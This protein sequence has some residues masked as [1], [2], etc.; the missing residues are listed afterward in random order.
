[1]E[2]TDLGLPEVGVQEPGSVVPM[3]FKASARRFSMVPKSFG[4]V[5]EPSNVIEG[6]VI[7]CVDVEEH[8]G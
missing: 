4:C 1:M 7:I 3:I 8:W 6:E 5:N 2:C